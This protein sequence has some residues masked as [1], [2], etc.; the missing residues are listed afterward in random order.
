MEHPSFFVDLE[1]SD[2]TPDSHPI[3]IAVVSTDTTFYALIR[4]AKYSAYWSFDAQD[5]GAST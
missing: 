3:E 2:I 4:P 1:A 5:T